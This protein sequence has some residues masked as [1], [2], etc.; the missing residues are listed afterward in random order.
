MALVRASE[1]LGNS[2][3]F[4]NASVGV[5]DGAYQSLADQV[6]APVD[7]VKLFSLLLGSLPLAAPLPYLP[8]KV[9]HVT[10]IIVSWVFLGPVL[11]LY[12]G[13]AQ[14]VASASL[15]YAIVAFGLGGRRMPW[16]VMCFQMGHLLTK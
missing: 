12:G 1:A 14:L 9:K 11:H 4:W 3:L 8:T 7:Y 13:Y 2:L 16:I 6:G 5:L 10:N 15:T